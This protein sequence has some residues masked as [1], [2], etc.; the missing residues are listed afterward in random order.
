LFFYDTA[1][2]EIYLLALPD[3]FPIFNTVKKCVDARIGSIVVSSKG[4]IIVD[5]KKINAFIA[6]TNFS[7]FSV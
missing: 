2:T 6:K 7:I 1:T 3:A 4:T 5:L